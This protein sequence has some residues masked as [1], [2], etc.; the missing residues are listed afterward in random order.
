M[1]NVLTAAT[2]ANPFEELGST[3]DAENVLLFNN[4]RF[5]MI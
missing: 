4:I 5:A 2:V 3:R 1:H